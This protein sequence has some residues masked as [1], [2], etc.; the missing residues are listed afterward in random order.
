MHYNITCISTIETHM[1]ISLPT[2]RRLDVLFSGASLRGW[3][4]VP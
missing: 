2:E 3:M 1:N 4:S